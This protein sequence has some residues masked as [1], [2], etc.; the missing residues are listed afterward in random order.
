[1]LVIGLVECKFNQIKNIQMLIK[2]KTTLVIFVA[3]TIPL[4]NCDDNDTIIIYEHDEQFDYEL[5][6][7]YGELNTNQIN[8]P[9]KVN[10]TTEIL[11][12]PC[13]TSN[14][15]IG[16]LTR[17]RD[18]EIGISL[19]RFYYNSR[20]LYYRIGCCTLSEL[21]VDYA[22]ILYYYNLLQVFSNQTLQFDTITFTIPEVDG[23]RCE[24]VPGSRG[25]KV[26]HKRCKSL[27]GYIEKSDRHFELAEV[28]NGCCPAR[29]SGQCM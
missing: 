2:L 17:I 5:Y 12:Q 23:E 9:Q 24:T 25:I 14:G 21:S 1:M 19:E 4:V 27:I 20:G 13:M 15:S 3:I 8:F 7:E 16:I 22:L 10:S 26:T 28:P 18:C 11:F 6:F 29:V